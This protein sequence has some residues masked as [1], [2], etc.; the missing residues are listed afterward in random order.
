MNATFDNTNSAAFAPAIFNHDKFGS[1]RGL[2][3]DG[4]PWFVA[5]DVCAYLEI[6][7]NDA[8]NSLDDDEKG[9]DT[10]VSPGGTQKTLLI[11]ESG[12]YSLI[13]RSRK[14]EAKIFKRWVTHE[15]I[16]AIRKHGG[17]LTPATLEE[18]LLDPD[19]LIRLAQDLKEERALRM[20]KETALALAAPKAEVYDSVVADKHLRLADFCRRFKGVNLNEVKKSLYKAGVLYKRKDAYRLYAKYRDTHFAEK[21]DEAHG[22]CALRVL[23]E[24]QK[25][26]TAL[27]KAGKLALKAGYGKHGRR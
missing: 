6:R 22:R 18:A 19:V 12:L 1:L 16:P 5:R 15:V 24:G 3:R 14:P 9:Y 27:Y 2:V 8:A 20:E 21:F 10:V 7:T 11:S 17:Y 25:L 4:E 23:P 13:L 26:L